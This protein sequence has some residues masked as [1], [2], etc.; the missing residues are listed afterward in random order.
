MANSLV[1]P[2]QGSWCPLSVNAFKV[3]VERVISACET[4]SKSLTEFATTYRSRLSSFQHPLSNDAQSCPLLDQHANPL[5]GSTTANKTRAIDQNTST[6]ANFS[7]KSL[8]ML[9]SSIGSI[10]FVADSSSYDIDVRRFHASKS[11]SERKIDS[12]PSFFRIGWLLEECIST[13]CQW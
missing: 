9:I 7:S 6:H 1:G 3:K 10:L 12:T 5:T 11:C 13:S 8:G 4:L 2:P